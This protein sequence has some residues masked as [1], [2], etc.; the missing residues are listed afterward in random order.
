MIYS[1]N[2]SLCIFVRIPL[3]ESLRV[4]KYAVYRIAYT[5]SHLDFIGKNA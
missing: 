5:V 1:S 3:A 2:K 4:K